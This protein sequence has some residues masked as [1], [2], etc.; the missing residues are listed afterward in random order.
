MTEDIKLRIKFIVEKAEDVAKILKSFNLDLLDDAG[1]KSLEKYLKNLQVFID[2]GKTAL[3]KGLS[4]Q[5]SLQFMEGYTKILGNFLNNWTK[6]LSGTGKDFESEFKLIEENLKP[7]RE[8]FAK[9]NA[10]IK[11]Y[12]RRFEGETVL[13]VGLQ[14]AVDTGI[15]EMKTDPSIP[16]QDKKLLDEL[17]SAKTLLELKEEYIK[18]LREEGEEGNKLADQYEKNG[19]LTKKHVTYLEEYLNA[20]KKSIS[21]EQAKFRLET[22]HN[23]ERIGA[24]KLQEQYENNKIKRSEIQAKLDFEANEAAKVKVDLEKQAQEAGDSQ[25]VQEQNRKIVEAMEKTA[26]QYEELIKQ[27]EEDIRISKESKK[28]TQETTKAVSNQGT[29]LAKAANQVFNYGLAFSFLRRI[30][31]ETLRTIKDLDKAF[32]EMAIVTT[33]SRK[34]AWQLADTMSDLARQTGFTTTEIS[35]LSTFYFRQGRALSEVIELTRVA[36]MSAR[37]AGISAADSANFLT[38]AVNGFGLA[39]NEVLA[40]SDRFAA[41][42]ANS[43]SSYEEL[44]IGLSKFAAQAKVAGVSMDFA[45]GLLAKGVETTREAPETIGTALKTVLARMRELTDFGKTLEDGMDIS[46][47]EGAL[48]QVG[49]ALRDTNGQF[50]DMEVV[51]S[52]I[53][54]SWEGFNREQQAS[55]AVALAGTRQQSRLI[56]MM[57]NFD[58]TLELVEISQDSAGATTAQH[59]EFMKSMEAA[60]VGLQTA[61]QEF[62]RNL[63]QSEILI[64][65]VKILTTLLESLTTALKTFGFAGRNAMV[66]L[67]GL[68]V[69]LKAKN[70]LI[71]ISGTMTALNTKILGK[72]AAATKAKT[73]LTWSDVKAE[74]AS[75]KAKKASTAATALQTKANFSLLGSL[76]QLIFTMLAKIATLI[77]MTIAWFAALGPIGWA[78]GAITAVG[79]AIGFLINHQKR[80][81]ERFQKMTDEI[82]AANFELR[83]SARNINSLIREME[84]LNNLAFLTEEQ[85]S[86]LEDLGEKLAELVGET[87]VVRINGVVNLELSQDLIDAFLSDQEE[88]IDKNLRELLL[89]TLRKS[90]EELKDDPVAR[91]NIADYYIRQIQKTYGDISAAEEAEFRKMFDSMLI[92]DPESVLGD[93]RKNYMAN[94]KNSLDSFIS[95][96]AGEQLGFIRDSLTTINDETLTFSESFSAFMAAAASANEEELK[97]L[98]RNF[99]QFQ[100]LLERYGDSA[101]EVAERLESIGVVLTDSIQEAATILGEGGL[102][103][104]ID[105]IEE[106]A[107]EFE[108]TMNV[109]RDTALSLAWS[110]IAEATEDAT[111]RQWMYA[112]AFK[113]T[114][115]E[116]GQDLDRIDSK[117]KN[118]NETQRK[119]LE[120]DLSSSELQNFI[121]SNAELFQSLEDVEN[122]LAGNRVDFN[123]RAERY[124]Q[125]QMA[126]AR[127]AA[128]T[129]ILAT[130]EE[131]SAEYRQALID[132]VYYRA[133]LQYNGALAETSVEMQRYNA[134]LAAHN[135][136]SEIGIVNQEMQ[137]QLF[138]AQVAAVSALSNQTIQSISNLESGFNEFLSGQGIESSFEELFNF[139]GGELVPRQD[140]WSGLSLRADQRQNLLQEVETLMSDYKDATSEA[141]DAFRDLRAA[142]IQQEKEGLDAQRKIYEDYF[143]ALDRLERQRERSQ[144]REDIVNQLSRL[145]GA[146]DERSRREATRLRKELNKLDQDSAKDTEAEARRLLFEGLDQQLENITETWNQA[147]TDFINAIVAGSQTA[148][149]FLRGVLEPTGIIDDLDVNFENLNT[150]IEDLVEILEEQVQEA[151]DPTIEPT[152]P[153]IGGDPLTH[154][155]I[156]NRFAAESGALPFGTTVADPSAGRNPSGEITAR[157]MKVQELFRERQSRYKGFQWF[158]TL[159]KR[160]NKELDMAWAE[161]EATRL[162]FAKGGMADFEGLAMLHGSRSAPEAV[163]NPSQTQMFIGLRDALEKMNFSANNGGSVNIE[164]ISISTASL[165]NNQDFNRAGETLAEAFRNAIQRKGVTINTN[166]N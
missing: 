129:R 39:A 51:L 22:T 70:I 93:S 134:L 123:A 111:L 54:R 20:N 160:M 166:K 146:T 19:K 44:A 140:I 11:E 72:N 23:A 136:L 28:S 116:F 61:Y 15:E 75:I 55:V 10:E 91:K 35:K 12:E 117:I 120:G 113:R 142:A 153:R 27:K 29:T 97:S 31:R 144:S 48:R 96:T 115:L 13:K 158:I 139:I 40:V 50:R 69:A 67:I 162:G 14:S 42:A 43:A 33:M 147:G 68:G 2:Q 90:G 1:K 73:A 102:Q 164:N 114:N 24:Q 74:W 112:Q 156:Y 63:T 30:Y 105:Q 49:I 161:Q 159:Q 130:A 154:E 5:G 25:E 65:I 126:V 141:F 94:K 8:E 85:K 21:T 122:F 6:I 155:E 125:Q 36:A 64:G 47:V 145:E 34:E 87:N 83:R 45:M 32:T 76:K 84:K 71:K 7:A 78:I 89:R 121:D 107:N 124:Q 157:S 165:N 77:K 98:Q 57:E 17:P 46:R 101:F 4:D 99:P 103:R 18:A 163:L 137:V 128:S 38:S 81:E 92:N 127:L 118:V 56:A 95:S 41:I 53:G 135:R 52:D 152:I 148:A 37:I 16:D 66:V 104:T 143:A 9:L 59:V 151:T 62:I 100:M 86:E 133:L 138:E 131:D 110:A 80:S 58:R 150:N 132:Q 119:W 26:T 60:T 106:L 88:E 149:G 79:L 109:S 108:S 3:D 82:N